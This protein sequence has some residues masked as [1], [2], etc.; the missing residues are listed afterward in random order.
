MFFMKLCGLG[1]YNAL[2]GLSIILS[3]SSVLAILLEFLNDNGIPCLCSGSLCLE[4]IPI[5]VFCSLDVLLLSIME[6]LWNFRVCR[7]GKMEAKMETLPYDFII[8]KK[9]ILT[10]RRFSVGVGRKSV[11]FF[12]YSA[13]IKGIRKSRSRRNVRHRKIRGFQ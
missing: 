6:D 1:S 8:S 11:M 9:P 3:N 13:E 7:K 5:L 2:F 12:E 10:N 4:W